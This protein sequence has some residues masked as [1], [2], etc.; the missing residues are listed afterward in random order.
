MYLKSYRCRVSCAFCRDQNYCGCLILFVCFV[1]LKGRS[2]VSNF[3]FAWCCMFIRLCICCC[4]ISKTQIYIAKVVKLK[5]T[6]HPIP[7]STRVFRNLTILKMSSFLTSRT[8]PIMSIRARRLVSGPWEGARVREDG[9]HSGGPRGSLPLNVRMTAFRIGE[10]G[11]WYGGER[12]KRPQIPVIS[13]H[14]KSL[15]VFPQWSSST[16]LQPN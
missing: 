10:G 16:R 11:Q 4:R 9:W 12:G 7:P 5:C 15:D 1:R 8:P 6:L 13:D 14:D 2:E 3:L